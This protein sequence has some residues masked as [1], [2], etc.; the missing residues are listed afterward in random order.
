MYQNYGMQHYGAHTQSHCAEAVGTALA[1]RYGRTLNGPAQIIAELCYN[2]TPAQSRKLLGVSTRYGLL[3]GAVPI[4]ERGNFITAA[5]RGLRDGGCL[6]HQVSGQGAGISFGAEDDDDS[7]DDNAQSGGGF[8]SGL[9]QTVITNITGL[10]GIGIQAGTEAENRKAL[11]E[12]AEASG[13]ANTQA[14]QQLLDSYANMFTNLQGQQQQ[15]AASGD[16]AAVA[17]LQAE[18][19]AKN[20]ELAN[21][22]ADNEEGWSPMAI[23]GVTVGSLLGVGLVVALIF[24]LLDDDDGQSNLAY[25]YY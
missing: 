22:L 2:R 9:F 18:I 10:V 3:S 6:Y 1:N 12:A 11:K 8:D 20:E 19:D 24:K 16:S 4:S 14:N 15:A 23:A 21:Q 13:A 5:I 17:L 7:A 25:S